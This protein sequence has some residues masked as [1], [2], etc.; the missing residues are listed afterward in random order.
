[1]PSNEMLLLKKT[2]IDTILSMEEIIEAV[3]E[4]LKEPL[5]KSSSASSNL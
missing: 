5:N 1:M 2:S 4:S 3:E